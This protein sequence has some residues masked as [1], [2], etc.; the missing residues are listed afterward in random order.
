M[1]LR[2]ACLRPAQHLLRIT[3]G[4]FTPEAPEYY[5]FACFL[6]GQLGLR[7]VPGFCAILSDKRSGWGFEQILCAA[8]AFLRVWGH[9]QPQPPVCAAWLQGLLAEVLR[10]S[11]DGISFTHSANSSW[12]PAP[13]RCLAQ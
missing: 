2:K 7:R 3:I 12:A 5:W 10:P 1:C 6:N 4:E 13:G 11:S 9:V 8:R